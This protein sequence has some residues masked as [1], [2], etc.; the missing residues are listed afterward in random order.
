MEHVNKRIFTRVPPHIDVQVEAAERPRIQGRTRD[1]CMNGLYM[2][3]EA[4]LPV[5]TPCRVT[6]LLSGT[7]ERIQVNGRVVRV[8]GSGMAMCFTEILGLESYEHLRNLLLHNAELAAQ[9]EK[10]LNESIGL[11][12]LSTPPAAGL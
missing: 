10:E 8:D 9:I 7:E 1:V 12:R 5:D 2:V 6:L 4:V 11:K 3:S